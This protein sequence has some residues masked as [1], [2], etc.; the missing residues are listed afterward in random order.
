MMLITLHTTIQIQSH[1]SLKIIQIITITMSVQQQL[2]HTT[3]AVVGTLH[4][5]NEII[6][7]LRLRM[8]FVIVEKATIIRPHQRVRVVQ[9]H[10]RPTRQRRNGNQVSFLRSNSFISSHFFTLIIAPHLTHPIFFILSL[11][12]LIVA[13]FYRF[14]YTFIEWHFAITYFFLN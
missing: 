2:Q 5:V 9:N 3:T 8:S 7:F 11:A 13:S 1:S 6:K 4:R 14:Y 10:H 12:R